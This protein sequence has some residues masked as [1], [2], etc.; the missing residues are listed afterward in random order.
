MQEAYVRAFTHLDGFR[1]EFDAGDVAFPHRHQR[2]AWT[3]AQDSGAPARLAASPTIRTDRPRS[4]RFPSTRALKIRS[5]RWRSG[6]YCNLSNGRRTAFPTV[7]R[8][9]FVA[10][11]IEGLSI[12][13]TAEPA[14][15]AAGDGQ[16]KAAPRPSARAQA[17]RRTD[18]PGAARRVSVC[19]SALRTAD[20]R[21]DETSRLSRLIF[22]G[23]FPG[24]RHPMTVN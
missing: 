7:Y 24:P 17:T 13:E 9:V 8:T 3:S 10:R 11:V 18:R 14:R 6:R 21:G 12:E 5:G 15:R 23:T 19:G 22:S 4:F 16:D 20:G 1:G 2:G